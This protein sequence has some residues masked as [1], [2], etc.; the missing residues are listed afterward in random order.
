MTLHSLVTKASQ[1]IR[2]TGLPF[3]VSILQ[4]WPVPR[5]SNDGVSSG[6]ASESEE[7]FP[8]IAQATCGGRRDWWIHRCRCAPVSLHSA[9]RSGSSIA[10]ATHF[11]ECEPNTEGGSMCTDNRPVATS[12]TTDEMASADWLESQ[13]FPSRPL[14]WRSQAPAVLV[15]PPIE[16]D[17]WMLD[18]LS[19]QEFPSRPHWYRAAAAPIVTSPQRMERETLATSRA[20]S[21]PCNRATDSGTGGLFERS[22][23]CASSLLRLLQG[24]RIPGDLG[25]RLIK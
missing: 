11:G 19:S 12:R 16:V 8:T 17:E 9:R 5:L 14:V 21:A 25:I 20:I 4:I 13:E 7:R 24:G 18:W 3:F 1:S 2:A 6:R 22:S 15:R 10:L 23:E